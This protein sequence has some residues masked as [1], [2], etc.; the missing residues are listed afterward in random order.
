MLTDS[1]S[2]P[3]ISTTC[4]TGLDHSRPD[5][6]PKDQPLRDTTYNYTS[7]STGL[8][9]P[10]K[11][12]KNDTNAAQ[13][14]LNEFGTWQCRDF[15]NNIFNEFSLLQNELIKEYFHIAKT[16]GYVDA[17]RNLLKRKKQLRLN[18]LNLTSEDGE[19][20]VFATDMANLC[21]SFKTNLSPSKALKKAEKLASSYSFNFAEHQALEE[22]LNRLAD[23]DWWYRQARQIRNQRLFEIERDMG[24]VSQK[25]TPYAS[26]R[27]IRSAR[28]AKAR[29]EEFMKRKQL[30]N[31][32]GEKITL[33]DCA[34]SNVSNPDVRFAEL[35]VR[36]KGFEE[37]ANEQGHTG[38]FLT[39]TTPSRMHASLS[40]HGL[41][42]PKFDGTTPKQANDYLVNV[43][44]RIRAYLHRNNINPYGFR[45]A[46]PH[47]D[48]TPHWHLLLFVP[49][50]QVQSLIYAY[51][52]YALQDSPNE[53]GAQKQRFKAE[54]IDPDKGSAAGYVVKYI[55]KSISGKGVGTDS[56][57]NEAVSSAERIIQ[58]SRDNRIRQFQ[59]IGG[60]S[61][62][63][64][65]ELRR[66]RKA[67]SNPTLEAARK[68]ADQS[69]WA[70]Y[71]RAMGGTNIGS[72]ERPIKAHYDHTKAVDIKTGEIVILDTNKYQERSAKTIKGLKLGKG[73]MPT[74]FVIWH[75]ARLLKP[76]FHLPSKVI[77]SIGGNA[78]Q[79]ASEAR[80]SW[81]CVN[82][83]TEV[84]TSH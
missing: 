57:G 12:H 14:T 15:R 63:V 69:D 33:A 5:I 58:W 74:R 16:K 34:A 55:S 35:M 43:G 29:T 77:D 66:L 19:L 7:V 24:I 64:W 45:V 53:K 81:T 46:E 65:R 3:A 8:V 72:S 11:R 82:N 60:A 50:H 22:R 21:L 37:L 10:E 9:Q 44:Q 30:V 75:S 18:D 27:A 17:N 32:S 38:V 78:A 71:I 68:A 61:V 70:A 28:Y 48:G 31:H 73:F 80:D 2:T 51:R 49:N 41:R 67:C 26:E 47:H 62:T 20:K 59:Q 54:I 39:L 76:L 56:Y 23:R 83:C 1:G 52:H 25:T 40:K 36:V 13:D 42:N 6:S 4:N 79:I 84:A